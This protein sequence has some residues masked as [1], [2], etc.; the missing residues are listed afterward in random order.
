[1]MDMQK[2]TPTSDQ[3]FPDVPRE[4]TSVDLF[5]SES[6][7]AHLRRGIAALNSGKGAEHELIEHSG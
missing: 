7:M 3:I 6:H 4:D 1:M 5:H 2:L